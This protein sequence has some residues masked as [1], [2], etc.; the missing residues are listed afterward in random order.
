MSRSAD[1][2][3]GDL[4]VCGQCGEIRGPVPGIAA[5]QLCA[6]ASPE[7]RRAQPR[8]G[9]D[10]ARWIELC[11][12]CG[13]RTVSSGSRW[14]SFHCSRCRPRVVALNGLV[15]RCVVPVG[16]HSLM[17]GVSLSDPVGRN[18]VAFVAFADQLAAFF[19][20]T[21]DL[22]AWAGRVVLD[23]LRVLG[24]DPGADVVLDEY[25]GEVERAGL[26]CEDFFISLVRSAVPDEDCS[27]LVK[28]CLQRPPI[29]TPV[30]PSPEEEAASRASVRALY[31]EETRRLDHHRDG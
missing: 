26:Q 31:D 13:L 21:V 3:H 23:H 4:L 6:C 15:G 2:T 1:V 25:L 7:E 20:S 29:A 11:R 30:P 22:E 18:P 10:F 16:R 8:H 24:F 17:N 27:T 14:S 12:T 28:A 19:S 5:V 9:R